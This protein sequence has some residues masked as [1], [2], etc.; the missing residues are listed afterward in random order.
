MEVSKIKR[1]IFYFRGLFQA[2]LFNPGRKMIA[3]LA[4]IVGVSIVSALY[5]VAYDIEEQMALQLRDYGANVIQKPV[6]KTFTEKEM[7]AAL[8]QIDKK[9]LV[10]YRPAH[11]V[12]GLV[13]LQT[14]A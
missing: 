2:F 10:A 13:L 7:Y 1:T 11:F 9:D 12:P 5:L 4:I 6:N 8:D 14:L 3:L